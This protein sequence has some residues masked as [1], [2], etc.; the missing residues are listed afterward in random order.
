MREFTYTIKSKTGLHTSLAG[1]LSMQTKAFPET[2][3]TVSAE[4]NTVKTSQLMR[5]MSM[6]F[7]QGSTVTVAAD[8]PQENDAIQVVQSFFEYYL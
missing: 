4:G 3:V 7:K 5:L 2:K 1:L 8:G 6:N